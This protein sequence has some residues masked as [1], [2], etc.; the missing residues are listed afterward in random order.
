VIG[1]YVYT[2]LILFSI[3]ISLRGMSSLGT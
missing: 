2:N 1:K 3:L